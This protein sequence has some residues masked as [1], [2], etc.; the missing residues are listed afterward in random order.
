MIRRRFAFASVVFLVAAAL[1]P[2]PAAALFPLPAAA[3]DSGQATPS[4]QSPDA[5][6]ALG[7]FPPSYTPEEL[8]A[9][10]RALAAVNMNRED[11]R[12]KKDYTK[13]YECLPV[14]LRLMDDPLLIAP[15]MDGFADWSKPGK[16]PH[17]YS[18][19]AQ[20]VK[21]LEDMRSQPMVPPSPTGRNLPMEFIN[22]VRKIETTD[23]LAA[24][25]EAFAAYPMTYGVE[26]AEFDLLR[27]KL[28][29]QMAWHDVFKSPFDAAKGKDWDAALEDRPADYLYKL[30]S[31]IDIVMFAINHEYVFGYPQDWLEL[32]PADAFPKAAPAIYETKAGRIAIGTAGDDTYTGNFAALIDPGGN[33]HYVNCIIGAAYGA[34]E[35]GIGMGQIGFFADLGGNDFYD[36]GETNITL[37]AAVLGIAAFY[38][39][40]GGNDRYVAGS[41]TLGAAVGGVATFYDDGG[42]DTYESKV[43]TQGAAGFGIG[44]MVD[45][46]VEP[47]PDIPT[48]VETPDPVAIADFDNDYYFAWT[49]AQAFARTKAVA[50]CVNTRGNE[51]YHAGGVYLH[52]PL[53]ADRYQSFSQGFAIGERDIDY[54]GGIAMLI[55]YA[56][57][58][59]YL[60]DIYNQGVGYWYSAGFLWDGAGNDVYEMTQ[61]GQGSGIHLAIGGLIDGGGH[62]T[63]VMHSGLG[64]GGSH[65]FAASV[66][67]DRGGDDHYMGLTSCNGTGLTN[68]VGLF[69]DRSGNDIYAGRRDGY[70][71]GGRPDRGTA[72]IGVFV[73][74]GGADDYLGKMKDD[75][76]WSNTS[77]GTGID[78]AP[79]PAKDA[80]PQSG[81][82]VVSGQ[83]PIP[84]VC[85]YKGEITQEVF[86]ELWEISIRWEVGDNRYIV[87]EARKRLIEFGSSVLPYIEKVMDN[88]ASGLAIRAFDDVLGRIL[89]T[90]RA[91]V[92]EVIRRNA[93]STNEKRKLISLVV[94]NDLKLTELADEVVKYLDDPD[95][96]FV[97]RAA[98]VLGTLGSHAGDERLFAMAALDRDEAMIRAAI[99]ALVQLK[100]DCWPQL[101]ALL[102]YPKLTVREAAVNLLVANYDFFGAQMKKDLVDIARSARAPEDLPPLSLRAVRSLLAAF[103]RI[104]A[105][106]DEAMIYTVSLLLDDTDWGVRADAARLAM[107]WKSEYGLNSE[108]RDALEPL[109]K[110]LGAM[111]LKE[112]EPY[113]KFIL[114]NG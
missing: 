84:E 44:I 105:Q 91:G 62:D 101:R 104:D 16:R 19:M 9:L 10:D 63:Y 83:A 111:R 41:C 68:S 43:Y 4:A 113:V 51:V 15:V 90:D 14:V 20:A 76:A 13:G 97:R 95:P 107:R 40:G 35:T 70:M 106:P 103:A 52:A 73:D 23:D 58:D 82:N 69:F 77:F 87:P 66:L 7:Y 29:Y 3:Q 48:D 5:A 67:M 1:F 54:A 86:D 100:T 18:E 50:L 31:K 39:L 89:E 21:A 8:A 30:A 11:L 59:R 64:Q 26:G 53:F 56:G 12:F 112:S 46:S 75:G 55:D 79:P 24:L 22:G 38:D 17:P 108:V 49:N 42:S 27:Y 37:G 28:P 57:N 85:N 74:L 114:E 98:G 47:A 93:Q 36:C 71:N 65:D 60:G 2:L 81:P 80:E 78:I 72:S 88:D 92:L 32:I 45:D 102:D 34:P 6:S 61:Y 33:D 94:I 99:T 110:K 25:L 96:A 109:V